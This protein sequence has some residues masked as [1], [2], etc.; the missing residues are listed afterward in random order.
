MSQR[1]ILVA[2]TDS[3]N[4]KRLTAALEEA[5]YV[6]LTASNADKAIQLGEQHQPDLAILDAEVTGSMNCVAAAHHL[7]RQT[8]MHSLFLTVKTDITTIEPSVKDGTL[9][10]LVKP[11]KIDQLIPLVQS[12]VKCSTELRQLQ[13]NEKKLSDALQRNREISVSIGIYMERFHT[14]EQ[15]AFETLRSFARSERRKLVEIARDLIQVTEGKN[16]LI[17]R[18]NCNRTK[19]NRI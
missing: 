6:V 13:E 17:N 14:T 15:E 1:T 4:L 5:G 3:V 12:A 9:G 16:N 11:L 2:D 7:H 8:G 19:K 10:Y 18:I